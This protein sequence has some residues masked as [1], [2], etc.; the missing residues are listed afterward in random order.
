[1][2]PG[3]SRFME[4]SPCNSRRVGERR[5]S[6]SYSGR[7]RRTFGFNSAQYHIRF[8]S[9]RSSSPLPSRPVSDPGQDA[10]RTLAGPPPCHRSQSIWLYHF[11]RQ[12][13]VQWSI[14][15]STIV[16]LFFFGKMQS[17]RANRNSNHSIQ[18]ANKGSNIHLDRTS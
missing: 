9:I 1:M 11:F 5:Q 7:P 17:F 10:S 15:F 12:N 8:K 14:H 18:T 3:N 13:A 16:E 2:A 4:E 6:V